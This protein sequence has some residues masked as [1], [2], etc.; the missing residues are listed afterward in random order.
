[1]KKILFLLLIAFSSCDGQTTQKKVNVVCAGNSLTAGPGTHTPTLPYP[2]QLQRLLGSQFVVTNSGIGGQ[3]TQDIS[4]GYTAQ[5]GTYYSSSTYSANVVVIWE[6]RN[7]LAVNNASSSVVSTSQAYTNF[8]TLCATARAT[9]YKIVV[10]TVTPSWTALYKNVSTVTG[11]NNLDADRVT[12]NASIVANWATF[13][14]A[15]VDLGAD[16]NLGTLG[17]NAQAGYVYSSGTRPTQNT[18][19]DDGTHF[20]NTGYGYVAEKIKQAILKVL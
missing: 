12:V 20:I 11:Y 4:T 5:I 9:G 2:T 1:M 14:D 15:L 6:V 13:A 16:T 3:T 8:T 10:V 17:Q 7:D 18:W 19:Y